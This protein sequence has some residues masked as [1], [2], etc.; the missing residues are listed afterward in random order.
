MQKLA[1]ECTRACPL[2]RTRAEIGLRLSPHAGL[3]LSPH[4]QPHRT[5][6]AASACTRTR[7]RAH[8]SLCAHAC[9]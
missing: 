3:R 7:A 1:N 9:A 6:A 2:K 5:P 8:E 4:A